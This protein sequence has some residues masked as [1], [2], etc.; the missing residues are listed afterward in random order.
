[1]T[2]IWVVANWG[3]DSFWCGDES[4]RDAH[5][6]PK[7]QAS[8]QFYHMKCKPS[9]IWFS[10][11]I[12]RGCLLHGHSICFLICIVTLQY[13]IWNCV[14]NT[15][16]CWLKL[17]P[18]IKSVVMKSPQVWTSSRQFIVFTCI[19]VFGRPLFITPCTEWYRIEL[20]SLHFV[21]PLS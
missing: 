10:C 21:R 13:P 3:I 19:Q 1:M 18:C 6:K 7:V 20:C 8:G 17:P 5:W 15:I 11:S 16:D 14:T 2:L 12:L 4:S 9:S